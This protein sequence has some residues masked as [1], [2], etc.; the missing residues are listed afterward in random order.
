MKSKKMSLQWFKSVALLFSILVLSRLGIYAI[1]CVVMVLI[2]SLAIYFYL[3]SDDKEVVIKTKKIEFAPIKPRKFNSFKLEQLKR[4]NPY[5]FEVYVASMYQKIGY[6]NAYVTP[7]SNDEGRDVIMNSDETGQLYYVECKRYKDKVSRPTIEKLA[8]AC[9]IG[10]AKGIII[11]TGSYTE[12]ALEFAQ[13]VGI[14]CVTAGRL[15]KMIELAEQNDKDQ[16]QVTELNT[17]ISQQ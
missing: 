2:C 13:K 12:P 15:L 16:Q 4:M 17:N 10:N 3:K 14:E 5:Q 9:L 11:T 6:S 7:K 8:G 1:A